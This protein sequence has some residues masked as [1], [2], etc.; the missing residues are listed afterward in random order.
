MDVLLISEDYIKSESILDD[1]L[2]GKYLLTAIKFAQDIELRSILGDKFLDSIQQLVLHK[3]IDSHKEEKFLLDEYIQPFLLY[4][5]LSEVVVPTAFKINN[6]GVQKVDDE[7]ASAYELARISYI[8]D[9]Y[10]DKANI[11]KKRLQE[12]LCKNGDQFKFF[13]C[14]DGNTYSSISSPIWLGGPRGK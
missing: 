4:Q 14:C 7:K 12:Y 13:K 6:F 5:V 9:Y 10:K 1:N 3:K 8:K 11:Y 2:S